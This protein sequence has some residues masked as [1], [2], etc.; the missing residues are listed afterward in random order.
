MM[1]FMTD[2]EQRDIKGQLLLEFQETE[3]EL[4]LLREKART[5]AR[6]FGEV[7]AYMSNAADATADFSILKPPARPS[8]SELLKLE[9]ALVLAAQIDTLSQKLRDLAK[10]K[11]AL[12]LK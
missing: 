8:P 3:H 11:E 7:S 9:P 12:G 5:I 4:A 6:A 2:Q 1:T 10:R